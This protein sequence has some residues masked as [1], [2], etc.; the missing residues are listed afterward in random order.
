MQ[1]G[2]CSVTEPDAARLGLGSVTVRDLPVDNAERRY[3]LYRPDGVQRPAMTVL[4]LHGYGGSA[5]DS[6][7]YGLEPV[8]DREGF[9]VAYAEAPAGEWCIGHQY[10]NA[11]PAVQQ[12]DDVAYLDALLA[13]LAMAV[14]AG[15]GAVMLLGVSMGGMMAI[16]Y[17]AARPGRVAALAGVI[18]GM[19][20]RQPPALQAGSAVP[21]LLVIGEDD[22]LLPPDHGIDFAV[23][24]QDESPLWLLSYER[25]LSHWARWNGCD[26]PPIVQLETGGTHGQPVALTRH[27]WLAEGRPRVMGC[28]ISP[29]GHRWPGLLQHPR[30]RIDLSL[31][32]KLGPACAWPEGAELVWAFFAAC[33]GQR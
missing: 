1:S 8:A 30:E 28:R 18:S 13:D 19:T 7:L 2:L 27:V 17:A 32:A 6:R 14:P 33:A 25:T 3:T 12:R 31:G 5:V 11:N 9:V 20:N 23:R 22:R 4:V 10:R 16:S 24:G 21:C 29:L 26:G 15:G